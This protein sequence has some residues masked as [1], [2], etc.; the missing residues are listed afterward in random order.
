MASG[1]QQMN[2]PEFRAY[3][4]ILPADQPYLQAELGFLKSLMH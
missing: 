3:G 4:G 2:R 1:A